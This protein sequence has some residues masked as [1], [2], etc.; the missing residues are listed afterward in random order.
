[1]AG[2]A[3]LSG[4]GGTIG[5]VT[6]QILPVTD[7]WRR[8]DAWLAARLPAEFE[9]LNPPADPAAIRDAERVLGIG[10]PADLAE[11][12]RS[13]DG[14]KAQTGLLPEHAGPLPVRSIAS[15]WQMRMDIA[16]TVDGLTTAPWADEPWWHPQWVPW[17][18]SAGG[19][20]QVID[21]RPGPGSGRVGWAV[22][23]DCGDFSDSWPSLAGLLHAVAQAL[24]EGGGVRGRVP[25]I[26]A[27][28][29][30]WWDREGSQELSGRP[31]RPAPVGLP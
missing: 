15:Y 3:F 18:E 28:G 22:H 4:P 21:Q 30:M 27:D 12:V 19:N 7:S 13:H 9:R 20:A 17:A 14:Q 6:Q 5:A 24:H 29:E 8:I 10:L 31:L 11:S 16:A 25:Y 26:T 23:D 1:M 2:G